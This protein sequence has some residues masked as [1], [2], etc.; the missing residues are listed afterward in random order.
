ME[1]SL[2]LDPTMLLRNDPIYIYIYPSVMDGNDVLRMEEMI[3]K[4]EER[5]RIRFL[6][7]LSPPSLTY[8]TK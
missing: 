1:D 7:S 2:A 8:R 6:Y 5:G 4:M 3:Y